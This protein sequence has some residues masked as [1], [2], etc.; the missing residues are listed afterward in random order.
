MIMKKTQYVQ[1]ILNEGMKDLIQVNEIWKKE[2]EMNKKG[3][4]LNHNSLW[5][6]V[7][8]ELTRWINTSTL[9]NGLLELVNSTTGTLTRRVLKNNGIMS[10][11]E[12]SNLFHEGNFP[13]DEEKIIVKNEKEK[14]YFILV[15]FSKNF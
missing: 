14:L 11:Y 12:F 1:H 5:E 8:S 3:S 7:A 13:S 9:I 2:K 4:W 6:Y 10:N 15:E